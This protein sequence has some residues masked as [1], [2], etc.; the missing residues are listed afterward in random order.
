VHCNS[1][2]NCNVGCPSG[3]TKTTCSDGYA[4]GGGC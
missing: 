2:T 1:V 4:C 3:V